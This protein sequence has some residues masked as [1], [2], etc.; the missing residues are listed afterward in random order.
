MLH[1]HT[2]TT[3]S[4]NAAWPSHEDA[5]FADIILCPLCCV[6]CVLWCACARVG[7]VQRHRDDH[8]TEQPKDEDHAEFETAA[9]AARGDAGADG[10]SPHL[11]GLPHPCICAIDLDMGSVLSMRN[12]ILYKQMQNTAGY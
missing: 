8:I 12:L 4:C 11:S 7:L 3:C 1:L 6:L 9:P 2:A 10:M 5:S